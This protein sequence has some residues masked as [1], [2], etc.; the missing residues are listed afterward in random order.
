MVVSSCRVHVIFFFK[1][2]RR[3]LRLNRDDARAH[4]SWEATRSDRRTRFVSFVRL[5]LDE[6]RQRH[7]ARNRRSSE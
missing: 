2:L 3:R 1:L 5:K 4:L 7:S 6:P